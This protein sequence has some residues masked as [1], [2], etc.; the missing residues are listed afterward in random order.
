MKLEEWKERW[1]NG[2]MKFVPELFEL[3]EQ[4]Q[5]EI[6]RM[7]KMPFIEVNNELR[8]KVERYE[9]ALQT[10]IKDSELF[11]P[12]SKKTTYSYPGKIAI[13]ALGLKD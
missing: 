8:E 10:I 12:T 9:K 3:V 5:K 1:N 2:D 7:G 4:Q 6:D 13:N 11:N